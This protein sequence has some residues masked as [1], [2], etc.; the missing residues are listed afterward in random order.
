MDQERNQDTTAALFGFPAASH[1]KLEQ[2]LAIIKPDAVDR[3]EE[4]IN[5]LRR[6]GFTI[7]QVIRLGI[8]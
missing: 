7:L 6:E 2:T 5:L 3:A 4:I 1:A 8:S